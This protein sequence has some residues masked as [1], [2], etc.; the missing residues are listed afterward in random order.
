MSHSPTRYGRFA[1]PTIEVLIDRLQ[2]ISATLFGHAAF[3]IYLTTREG[4]I[5]YGLTYE[6]LLAAFHQMDTSIRTLAAT[7]STPDGKVV[8]VSVRF[9]P[10]FSQG[11]GHFL[12][13]LGGHAENRSVQRMIL[14]EW[15]PQTSLVAHSETAYPTADIRQTDPDP[16]P[17][18]QEWADDYDTFSHARPVFQLAD[19]F[20]FDRKISIDDLLGFL[21]QLSVRYFHDTPFH[22]QLETTDGDFY[23]NIDSQELRYMF[24]NRRQVLFTL[25][26]DTATPDGQWIDFQFSFHPLHGGPN[27]EV[28]LRADQ[29]DG[30]ISLIREMISVPKDATHV[31]GIQ[32]QFS[33]DAE[34]FSGESILR[35]AHDISMDYLLK[36]P[37]VVFLATREGN[38]FTGLS[39]YQLERI[40]QRY[41]AE[42]EVLSVGITRALTGQTMSLMFQFDEQGAIAG[43]FSMNWGEA[44]L[45]EQIRELI[46]SRLLFS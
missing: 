26:L 8:R 39:L 3:N 34:H 45:Q 18:L 19:T 23:F 14:G 28:A 2:L 20:Y 11:R 6:E 31:S 35:L 16:I 9:D 15:V 17:D 27:G 33:L 1:F 24:R 4:D 32:W 22:A 37:P 21:E 38:N 13:A 25:F 41:E 40:Y 29:P 10:H 7:S 30:I 36:I 12:L 44:T 42:I 43:N 5:H 46:E